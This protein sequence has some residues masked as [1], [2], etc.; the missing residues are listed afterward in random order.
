MINNSLLYDYLNRKRSALMRNRSSFEEHW[1]LLSSQIQPRRGR[2]FVTEHNTGTRKHND[3]VNSTGTQSLRS[4]TAGMFA[5]I[6]SPSRPW[7]KL[8]L[9]DSE[10]MERREVGS[11]FTAV[12]RILRSVFN[13]S[14]LY[15]M[16]P[17][18]I[19]E[20]LLF[21]TGCMLHED[22][23]KDVVRF[24][25]QT[26][27]SYYLG[28][29][30]RYETD[31][32]LREFQMTAEQMVAAFG[33]DMVSPTIRGLY[34]KGS[35]GNYFTVYHL[36]EP[37]PERQFDSPFATN[38]AFRSMYFHKDDSHSCI[39][40]ESGFDEFPAYTPRWGTTGEDV[41]GTD[42]PGMVVLGDVLQ[43]QHQEK[44]KQQAIDKLVDP[45]LKGPA[46]L[47]NEQVSGFSGGLTL[48]DSAGQ[49]SGEF[50]P[51][52]Q[53]NP[54]VNTLVEDI[55]KTERRIQDGFF[56]DLFRAFT[57]L[58]GSQYK[59]Q[60][61]LAERNAER[62]LELGPVLQQFQ[63]EF[64]SKLID[65]TFY[66][67]VDM[68][69]LPP[70]PEAL[71]EQ[72]FNIRYISSLAQA[73][74][75]VAAEPIERVAQ[76]AMGLAQ[77]DPSIMDKFDGDQAIDEYNR[78][79]LGPARMVKNDEEVAEAREQRAQAEQ[80]QQQ[81]EMLQQAAGGAKDAASAYKEVENV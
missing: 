49:G 12:E 60:M 6:M 61:E 25:A 20:L 22:D 9:D 13:G 10:L 77:V 32:L 17:V 69:M 76:F 54:Q 47:R 58:A 73:Q 81:M 79:I 46:S 19:S 26:V 74:E 41:Y 35:Y 70:P 37:R 43:L 68:E 33:Y 8:A 75:A 18:M 64:L 31:T 80:M 78:A 52:F 55:H 42:C 44:K 66:R 34:D 21:G 7:F 72:E 14:N 39:L 23:E 71:Q 24:Y 53:V 62:L 65:R 28:Q 29:N 67:L 15:N 30:D 57:N 38:A 4:A 1:R 5:G 36:I 11:W 63:K 45:P 56:L 40:R 2:F 27:G 59:N 3:I 16:A 48:Y 50:G 51:L